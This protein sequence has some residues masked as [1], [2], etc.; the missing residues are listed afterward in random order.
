MSDSPPPFTPFLLAAPLLP[1]IPLLQRLVD[2][3]VRQV[4]TRHAAAFARL[5]PLGNATILIEPT[6]LPIGFALRPGEQPPRVELVS[7][8]ESATALATI[9]GPMLLLLDLLQGRLD[10]DAAFFTR[11]LTIE[12]DTEAVLLLRNVLDGAGIDLVQD[13]LPSALPTPVR[14][15]AAAALAGA[16]RLLRRAAA[17]LDRIAAA[18]AAPT[19]ARVNHQQ[20]AIDELSGRLDRLQRRAVRRAETA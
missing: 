1:P 8:I 16:E 9:R 10:G 7:G 6:D 20:M 3:L 13:A 12:G 14:N 11:D 2:A 19:T 15:R 4:V 18:I 17:D 5:A